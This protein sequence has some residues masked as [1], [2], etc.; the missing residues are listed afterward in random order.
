LD[1]VGR[2]LL[3]TYEVF[4]DDVCVPEDARLGDE[5]AGWRVLRDGLNMER[6]F[7]CG[8]Y[9]GALAT[10]IGLAAD[11]AA[12]RKQFGQAIAAFQ[13]VS[14]PI[15]D[16]Y[17][18]LAAARLLA[19][20]AARQLTAGVEARQVISVAKLF[21]TEAYQRATNSAMQIFGGY[22][23]MKEYDIERYWRDARIATVT[24]GTSQIQ[25]EII[26]TT[27]GLRGT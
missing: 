8:A 6:L 10:V 23:Y 4:L 27:L 22:G 9:A 19:Y 5:G 2:H 7:G 26:L 13:A 21:N 15:A 1:T 16:M 25:R 18:D 20:S 12:S 24:A 17:A 14:H 3:G 11:Y